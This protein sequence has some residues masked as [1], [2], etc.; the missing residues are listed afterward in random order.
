M[1]IALP[2][3]VAVVTG[4]AGGIGR[5]TVAGLHAAGATVIAT[6]LTNLP[7]FRVRRII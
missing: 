4:A 6:D 3:V 7:R 1:T 2:N 5:A